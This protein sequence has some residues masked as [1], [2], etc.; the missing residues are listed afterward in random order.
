VCA[1]PTSGG[2]RGS[3]RIQRGD[4]DPSF[5][6]TDRVGLDD[7]PWAYRTFLDKA[8]DCVKVVLKP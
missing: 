3:T 6:I 7:A 1:G 2:G 8:D 4:I 5:V